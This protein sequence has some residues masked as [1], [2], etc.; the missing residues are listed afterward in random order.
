MQPSFKLRASALAVLALPALLTACG[1][2]GDDKSHV[3]ADQSAMTIQETVDNAAVLVGDRV[4]W[5]IAATNSGATATADT[6][7]LVAALPAN[8]T[9]VSVVAKGA[10][11]G[12]AVSTLTCTIP[13]GLAPSASA[14]ILVS[15]TTTTPG[16][17]TTSVTGLGAGAKG[18]ASTT[19]CSASTTV[20]ARPIPPN[21]T[22]SSAVNT[23]STTVGGT[24]T[25]TLTAVNTGGPST[26]P[27]VLTDT[28]PASGIG[29]VTVTPTGAACNAVSGRTLTCTIPTGMAASA[30][31]TIVVSAPTTA[32]GSL[33]NTVAPD[34]NASC[35]TTAACTTTTSVAA[36]AIPNVTV[37]STVNK[38][39]GF[40]GDALTWTLTATNTGTGATTGAI[41]LTDTLPSAGIGTVTATPTGA[42][43]A[44]VSGHT[45]TCTIPAGLASGGGTASVVVSSTATA[46]GSLVN[47]VA[48]GTGATC[49]TAGACTTTTT[50]ASTPVQITGSCGVMMDVATLNA[51]F[52][53][54]SNSMVSLVPLGTTAASGTNVGT[55]IAGLAASGDPA[56]LESWPGTT[57]GPAAGT[58]VTATGQQF[59]CASQN[60]SATTGASSTVKFSSDLTSPTSGTPTSLAGN[61]QI[62]KQVGANPGFVMFNLRSLSEFSFEFFRAGSNGYSLDYSTDGTTWH[63]IVTTSSSRGACTGSVCDEVGL[64]TTAASGATSFTPT[65]PITQPLLLRLSNVNTSGTMVIQ[66]VMIK[67]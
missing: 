50:I 31:A 49:S 1:G 8:V 10:T 4:T 51:N 48:P 46:S 45:L 35:S 26:S 64:L 38:T 44:A 24:V 53:G 65:A 11:C 7:T 19:D 55:Y 25:W 12:P 37:S 18:C 66:K 41:T 36:A 32:V 17:L 57:N 58:M 33:V 2:G 62:S 9:G 56:V 23:T 52:G 3:P 34:T 61:L 14:T 59:I 20:S 13:S 54:A 27:I 40:V 60:G 5:T 28:L 6:T 29:T 30:T 42:T 67:P 16:A 21:V 22:V 15:G 43:C 39:T 63:N 47:T